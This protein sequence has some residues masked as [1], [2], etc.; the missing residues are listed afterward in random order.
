MYTK[1]LLLGGI[2]SSLKKLYAGLTTE[3]TKLT[4]EFSRVF[5]EVHTFVLR[6][7]LALREHRAEP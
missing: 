5:I 1:L 7:E 2:A 3:K 6:K 4:T